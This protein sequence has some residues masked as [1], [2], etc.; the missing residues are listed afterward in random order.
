MK[1]RA[2]AVSE[3][4]S[5][6]DLH[7][8]Y[9]RL[10][11][12]YGPAGWWPGDTPFEICIGAILTQNTAWSNVER[13]LAAVR[14]AGRLSYEGLAPLD[15]LRIARLIRPSGCYNVKARRVA[16]F[17]GFLGR[18]YGGRVEAMSRE[19]PSS[20]R[21]KLLAVNG[22][23]P[24]TADC[25]V[26][27]AA[28]LPLFVVDAYTRRVFERLGVLDGGESYDEVQRVFMDSLPTD[29]ALF[30][31]FHAQ[32]VRLAKDVCRVR[33]RCEACPL[34]ALCPRVGVR[35][36]EEP[37]S[38]PAPQAPRRSG[39]MPQGARLNGSNERHGTGERIAQ[40]R[41]R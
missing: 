28:G 9:R 1:P 14:A 35:G 22:I 11:R 40:R 38:C 19:E 21:R 13:A 26:L 6:H 27:Y 31:D 34:A 32:I 23:G 39:V 16:A 10:R 2:R 15:P 41:Q 20:L 7:H 8:L 25:I 29:A 18:E 24:E 30:N 5:R 37:G 36:A 3:L 12:R 17:L 4:L 33:P